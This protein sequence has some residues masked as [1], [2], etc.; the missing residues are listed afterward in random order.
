MQNETRNKA[1]QAD[2]PSLPGLVSGVASLLTQWD[3]SDYLATETAR[4]LIGFVLG[5]ERRSELL[6][7]HSQTRPDLGTLI[8]HAEDSNKAE[9]RNFD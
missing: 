7:Y 1:G 4:A 5:Y 2:T 8:R 3:C 9:L 6:G